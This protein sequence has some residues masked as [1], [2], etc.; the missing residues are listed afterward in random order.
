MGGPGSGRQEPAPRDSGGRYKGGAGC[1][2]LI[3]AMPLAIALAATGTF[4]LLG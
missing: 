4:W 1:L 2:I 3:A